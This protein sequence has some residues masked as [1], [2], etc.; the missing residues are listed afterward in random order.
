[1]DTQW[2]LGANTGCGFISHFASVQDDPRVQET[3]V[4]K[5]GPGCGKSTFMKKLRDTAAQLGADT[6]SYLCSS[7]PDSLDGLLIV[8][9]GLAILDGTAPH[10]VEPALCGCG[11]S[12]LNLG[13]FYDTQGLMAHRQHL[14]ALREE[15]AALYPAAYAQLK[16]AA[17]LKRCAAESLERTDEAGLFAFTRSVVRELPPA[18]NG[19]GKRTVRFLRSFTP[20]GEY[21]LQETIGA[22]CRRMIGISDAYGVSAPLLARLCSEYCRSGYDVIC[23]PDPLSPDRLRA[24]LVPEADTAFCIADEEAEQCS[25]LLR[26]SPFF[27]ETDEAK[28]LRATAQRQCEKA[29]CLLARAKAIHDALEAEYRPYVSFEGL[30]LLTQEYRKKIKAALLADQ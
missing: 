18:R 11:G 30:D 13:C 19:S 29:V 21:S 14:R 28:A 26:L 17:E 5:G 8:P 1:M 12:Y 10:V 6:E 22:V 9:I 24:L 23:V 27:R 15:N 7:D 4:L 3:I 16:A 2:F 25:V 20:R